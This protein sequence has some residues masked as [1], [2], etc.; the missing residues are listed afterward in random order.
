[1][2]RGCFRTISG[3][4]IGHDRSYHIVIV[5]IITIMTID[6]AEQV[7]A[8]RPTLWQQHDAELRKE[9]AKRMALSLVA[10]RVFRTGP[11]IDSTA[12]SAHWKRGSAAYKIFDEE[13]MAVMGMSSS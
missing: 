13:E 10:E 7:T 1:M 9:T 6:V 2:G 5:A 8:D 4:A 11:T 12:D 3:S